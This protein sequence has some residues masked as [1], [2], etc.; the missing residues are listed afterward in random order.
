[1]GKRIRS[2]LESQEK[3]PVSFLLFVSSLQIFLF[4]LN[5]EIATLHFFLKLFLKQV[6]P[7]ISI[8]D[9]VQMMR[10]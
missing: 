10:T 9:I 1:M 5:V 6:D 2:T 3:L 7:E 4:S 8:V